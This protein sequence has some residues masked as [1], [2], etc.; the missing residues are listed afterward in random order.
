MMSTVNCARRWTLASRTAEVAA[1]DRVVE[2][3]VDRVAVALVVLRRVD[4]PLHGDE[5][6]RRGES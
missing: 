3:T 6:A 1:L 2:E 5:F 4:V